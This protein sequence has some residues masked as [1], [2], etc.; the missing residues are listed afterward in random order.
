MNSLAKPKSTSWRRR[1][2]L[3]CG[4]VPSKPWWKIWQ[5]RR[6]RFCELIMAL[7]MRQMSSRNFAEKLALRGRPQLSIL[8]NKMV[9]LNERIGP[10]WKLLVPCYVT[11]VC[12]SFCGEK[13]Q[14][15]LCTYKTNARIPHWTSKLLK[16]FSLVRNLTSHILEFLDV[17]FTFICRKRRGASWML[18][19]RR[20]CLWATGKIR[21]PIESMSLVKGKWRYATMSLLMKMLPWRK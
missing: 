4:S 6:S 16:S 13:L 8:L 11:K 21:R 18:L 9:L 20:E 7:N 10:L 12:W 1:M 3:S 15:L 2:R 17:L 5:G 14:T 19:G